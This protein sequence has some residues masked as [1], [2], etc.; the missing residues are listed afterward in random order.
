MTRVPWGH[1]KGHKWAAPCGCF[2]VWLLVSLP[3]RE[4]QGP[5][6]PGIPSRALGLLW[7]LQ[8]LPSD[9][10]CRSGRGSRVLGA[11]GAHSASLASAGLC[12]PWASSGSLNPGQASHLPAPAEPPLSRTLRAPAP[13]C[14]SSPP[15]CRRR[16]SCWVPVRRLQGGKGGWVG[17]GGLEP[18]LGRPHA[19]GDL[20]AQGGPGSGQA[21]PPAHA[22]GSWE[23]TATPDWLVR[24]DG[25]FVN[26][27]FY[28]VV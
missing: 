24:F 18:G 14:A 8:P 21:V 9:H 11:Q 4:R 3:C 1:Q 6:P 5:G 25:I 12:T 17:G 22:A 2:G 10:S 23:Q 19:Y 13:A 27:L 26:M 20:A 7:G 16:L 28:G 15:V